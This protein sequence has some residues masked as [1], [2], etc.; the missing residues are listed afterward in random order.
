MKVLIVGSGTMSL[1]IS[2]L[3]VINESVSSV[4]IKTRGVEK[5]ETFKSLLTEKL[6]KFYIKRG[7]DDDERVSV[8]K[9]LAKFTEETTDKF[10]FIIEAVAESLSV[11]SECF[12]QLRNFVGDSTIVASNTSSLSITEL[13][14][15]SG[16]PDQFIGLHFFNPA[17]AMEL[18]EVVVGHH[19]SQNTVEK[20]LEFIKMLG[21]TPV[22]VNDSPGFIVNRM[23]IPMIN[24]A[25]SIVAENTA[26]IS[27][28]DA[29][30][31]LGAHHPMGPLAL[32]DFIGLD[33]VVD[34]M[35]TLHEETGDQKYR[36]H[37]LLKRMVRAN[38]LGRKS[39]KGFYSY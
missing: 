28:V 2:Q 29:A 21:K 26:E 16:Y 35:N 8:D 12:A 15:D 25:V 22:I 33:V 30:M 24:E 34:I 17:P 3:F 27:D 6:T 10:D 5:F 19:T 9:K 32:A 38:E 1:G 7:I 39:G 11:K 4:T 14:K 20:S 23:L 13:A 37:P 18:V 36:V 31:K